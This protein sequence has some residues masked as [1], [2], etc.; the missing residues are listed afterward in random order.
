MKKRSFLAALSVMSLLAFKPVQVQA[1]TI[2]ITFSTYLPPTY[3]Y[4]W[5]PIQNFVKTV[6]TESDGRVKFKVFHSAQLY[7]GYQELSA[8]S[9]G[10]VDMV[11]MTGTYPSGTVPSLSIFTLPFMFTS[12]DHLERALNDGLLDLGIRQELSNDHNTVVLGVGPYDPYE[13]YSKSTPMTSVNDVEGK[14]WATTG[15]IDAR[16][17]QLMGGSPTGMPSSELYLA[18]DRGVIDATPRPLLTGVGRKLYEV[19]DYLSLANFGI[20]TAIL[21]INKEKWDS[22]PKDIQEIISK[23]A[24][25]RDKQQFEMVREFVKTALTNFE[26]NGMTINQ[27]P[28][29]Q[30][31]EMKKLTAPAIE[32]WE[33]KVPN[34]K[35]YLDLIKK[36]QN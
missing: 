1:E 31:E 17:I 32:E 21:A 26:K 16:A 34:G 6:E 29:A 15:A 28:A 35:E 3:A 23:A 14:V 13:F 9:R 19:V 2:E 25:Q 4:V 24:A 11:N 12:V 33:Q 5:E 8:I 30:I 18:F 10:D 22:L 36:T 27:I 7:D 20:D